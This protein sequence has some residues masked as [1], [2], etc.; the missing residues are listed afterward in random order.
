MLSSDVEE[1]STLGSI[2]AEAEL[3]AGG[4]LSSQPTLDKTEGVT[5]GVT[6][7]VP[8]AILSHPAIWGVEIGGGRCG[9]ACWFW[10]APK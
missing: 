3:G 4:G 10:F 9:G 7:G 8:A 1:D 5:A 2:R 6:A